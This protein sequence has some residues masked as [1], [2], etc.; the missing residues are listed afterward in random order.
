MTAARQKWLVWS[1]G[2]A[3]LLAVAG[4]LWFAH[5]RGWLTPAENWAW[6]PAHLDKAGGGNDMAGM[7]MGSMS[8]GSAASS[9]DVPGQADVT[10]PGEV[11]QRIGVTIGTVEKAPLK[12]SIRAVGIVQADETK[13]N[14]VHL[15]T[16]GWVTKLYVD[17]TGQVVKKGDPLLAIYSPEFLTTQRNYLDDR[18]SGQSSLADL[19]RQRLELWDV[20]ADEIKKLE[21]SGKAKADLTL[22]SPITGTVLTKNTFA[23]QRVMP[24]KELY[25]IADL[26]TVW[27]QAKVYEY[28]LPHVEL[29][30]PAAVTLTAVPGREFTGKV[31]FIQPIVDEATRTAEVRVELP[32]PKGMFKPGMFANLVI[33]HMMGDGLLVPASAV[34]RTGERDIVF[35]AESDNRFLPEEVKIGPFPFGDRFEVLEGLKAGDRVSTSANFLIDSESRLQAG[36]GGM[37]G[38]AGMD[39]G[40]KKGGDMK[41][42]DM[43]GMDRGGKKSSQK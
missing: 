38:M 23:G 16:E 2:A 39:M 18:K 36:G 22:R 3:V 35:K 21:S 27:V 31:A 12:M 10:I 25:I 32:N 6:G 26:S 17:Y 11:Q 42:M 9:T 37:A 41:G 20:P 8:A 15:K 7:D 28:E 40:G 19:A 34:I 5:S 33:Q 1:A 14:H 4:G 29:G 30:Q 43:K 24:E 13:I